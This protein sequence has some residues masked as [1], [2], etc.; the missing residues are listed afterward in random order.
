MSVMK[1]VW[2][3][4]VNTLLKLGDSHVNCGKRNQHGL[5]IRDQQKVT[6]YVTHTIS[7]LVLLCRN[8]WGLSLECFSD[9]CRNN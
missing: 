8:H 9:I 7:F 2:L 6:S 3:M 4:L 1:S 5:L